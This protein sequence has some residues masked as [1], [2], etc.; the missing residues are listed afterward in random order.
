MLKSQVCYLPHLEILNLMNNRIK[1]LPEGIGALKSLRILGLK[2]NL[3]EELPRSF[4]ELESLK[5]QKAQKG[6]QG[7]TS[8]LC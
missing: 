5:V 6:R 4:G 8:G 2:G 7:Q 3:I 1:T